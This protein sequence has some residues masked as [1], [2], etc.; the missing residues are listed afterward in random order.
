MPCF[1]LAFVACKRED[2]GDVLLSLRDV[3]AERGRTRLSMGSTG[4][5]FL[6][7][8]SSFF[9]LPRWSSLFPQV[10]P[11]IPST[12]SFFRNQGKGDGIHMDMPDG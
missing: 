1:R 2:Y 10:K 7:G 8:R 3:L 5:F 9:P 6:G 4:Y 11:K 12:S